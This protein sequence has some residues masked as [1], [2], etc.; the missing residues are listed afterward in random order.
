MAVISNT[1][2]FPAGVST[3]VRDCSDLGVSNAKI[4]INNSVTYDCSYCG[5]YAVYYVNKYGG[6]NSFLFEGICKRSDNLIDHRYS[7][8]VSNQTINFE[9]NR[10]MTEIVPTYKLTT[11]WLTDEEAERLASDLLP[12][13][14]LYLHNLITDEIRPAFIT[15]S[16]AEYKTFRNNNKKFVQYTVSVQESQTRI[17][18]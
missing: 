15:D 18:R 17:R 7:R 11:G 13:T 5:D 14:K 3:W 8:S 1:K 16:V 10:Y 2:T 4:T 12:T 6:W 9:D